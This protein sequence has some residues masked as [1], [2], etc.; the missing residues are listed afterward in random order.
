LKVNVV[1]PELLSRVFSSEGV[2]LYWVN[3]SLYA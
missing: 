3:S 1:K 2:Y